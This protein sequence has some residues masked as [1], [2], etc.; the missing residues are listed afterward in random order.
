MMK[1]LGRIIP[2]CQQLC[3]AHG[4]QLVIQDVLY[5]KKPKE[6]EEICFSTSETEDEDMEMFDDFNDDGCIVS[7][8]TLRMLLH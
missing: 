8:S 4:L 5:Q 7:E 1:K 6:T 3:Y 2:N